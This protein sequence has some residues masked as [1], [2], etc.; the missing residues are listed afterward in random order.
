MP[1]KGSVTWYIADR[2]MAGIAK[3]EKMPLLVAARLGRRRS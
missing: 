2:Y 1:G 3:R